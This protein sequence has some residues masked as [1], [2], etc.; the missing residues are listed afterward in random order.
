VAEPI[1]AP[2]LPICP[3]CLEDPARVSM[4]QLPIGPTLNMLY[5]CGNPDCRKI[6][7]ISFVGMPQP[8]IV[9]PSLSGRMN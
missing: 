2:D 1:P 8:Q 4:L 6:L 9:V 7:A 3:W 5:F